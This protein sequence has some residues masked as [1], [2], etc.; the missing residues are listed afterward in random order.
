MIIGKL[1]IINELTILAIEIEF[2]QD[3]AQSNK[4]FEAGTSTESI[5]TTGTAAKLI[6]VE[7]PTGMR[8]TPVFMV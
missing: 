7:N 2:T 8:G 3:Y 1:S 5:A 4:Y 6:S